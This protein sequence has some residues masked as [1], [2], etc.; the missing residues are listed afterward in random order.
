M[1]AFFIVPSLAKRPPPPPPPDVRTSRTQP[2]HRLHRT[3]SFSPRL[4]AV[5]V[6]RVQCTLGSLPSSRRAYRFSARGGE[7]SPKR[8]HVGTKLRLPSEPTTTR[9]SA[10][11]GRVS[12]SGSGPSVCRPIAPRELFAVTCFRDRARLQSSMTR[13]K[14][15]PA[16]DCYVL[17]WSSQTNAIRRTRVI[18]R[19]HFT[20]CKVVIS[21]ATFTLTTSCPGQSH[22]PGGVYAFFRVVLIVFPLPMSICFVVFFIQ[23]FVLT[24]PI[25]VSN[26][27]IQ[28][29]FLKCFLIMKHCFSIMY[30]RRKLFK[31]YTFLYVPRTLLVINQRTKENVCKVSRQTNLSH[32]N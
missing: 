19:A 28:V 29:R 10:Q 14:R 13:V 9:V 20:C 5:R 11:S 27:T 30:I 21:N 25:N 2:D 8:F 26:E 15:R 18:V 16:L 31:R 1:Y 32:K 4:S 22:T 3:S 12:P 24:K 7:F 23:L 17:L 6:T